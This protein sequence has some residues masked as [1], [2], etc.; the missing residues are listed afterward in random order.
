MAALW[1]LLLGFVGFWMF[2]FSFVWDTKACAPITVGLVCASLVG[3]VF[4]YLTF[5]CGVLT[6]IWIAFSKLFEYLERKKFF[7]IVL[8][9]CKDKKNGRK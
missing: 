2:W 6:F 9:E 1:W 4:G 3:T 8:F 5:V 7:D